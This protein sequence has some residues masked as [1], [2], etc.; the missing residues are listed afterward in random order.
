MVAHNQLHDLLTFLLNMLLPG[1]N[2]FPYLFLL[3]TIIL[4]FD[5]GI[6]L[7]VKSF[8]LFRLNL[9]KFSAAGDDFMYVFITHWSY[10]LILEGIYR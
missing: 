10:G 3:Q 6:Q 1:L 9:S 5:E 2:I 8:D 7:I 4:R